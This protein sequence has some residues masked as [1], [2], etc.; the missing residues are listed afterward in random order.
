MSEGNEGPEVVIGETS[1]SSDQRETPSPE[2]PNQKIGFLKRLLDRANENFGIPKPIPAEKID[3]RKVAQAIR[4]ARITTTRFT[5]RSDREDQPL[6]VPDI[7]IELNYQPDL[8]IGTNWW[9]KYPDAY[10]AVRKQVDQM[11]RDGALSLSEGFKN[12]PDKQIF[13][14]QIKDPEAIIGLTKTQEET[15]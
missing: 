6:T 7:L 2:V 4:N 14:W 9:E 8:K 13:A 10:N 1:I 3:E 5:E 11:T 12:D 15:K